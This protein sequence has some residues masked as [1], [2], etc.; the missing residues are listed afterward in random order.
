MDLLVKIKI[1]VD[2]QK[3]PREVFPTV[4]YIDVSITSS[5]DDPVN[6]TLL[7]LGVRSR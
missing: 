4:V 3:Y 6:S 2:I 7:R 5:G 1:L